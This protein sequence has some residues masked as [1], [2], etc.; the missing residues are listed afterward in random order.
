MKYY[1]LEKDE[2]KLLEAVEKSEFK[3][4]K[5][6]AQAKTQIVTAARQSGNKTRNIN[7]RVPERLLL[8]LKAK[9][10]Q[11]GIPYQTLVASILHRSTQ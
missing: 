9:A 3:P 8:K 7:I 11:D 1:E 10:A 4:I 6:S 2:Q 5:K